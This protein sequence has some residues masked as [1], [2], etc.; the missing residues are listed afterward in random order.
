MLLAS[1]TLWHGIKCAILL[2]QSTTTKIKLNT[3]WVLGRPRMKSMLIS[4]QGVE[5]TGKGVYKP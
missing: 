3:L 5:T 2:K 1:S 4:Y